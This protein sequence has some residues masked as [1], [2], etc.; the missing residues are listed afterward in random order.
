MAIPLPNTERLNKARSVNSRY[1]GVVNAL[2]D[3]MAD[4]KPRTV[5]Q[6]QEALPQF[7]YRQIVGGIDLLRRRR[8]DRL[9]N[10]STKRHH[11]IYQIVIPERK[12]MPKRVRE[13]K[14][15]RRDP[16]E[17]MKLAMLTR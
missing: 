9:V 7:G 3:L 2:A 14:P 11:A 8:E 4:N 10:L 1:A 16:F 12:D 17:A 5:A 6:I 15:L 13:F